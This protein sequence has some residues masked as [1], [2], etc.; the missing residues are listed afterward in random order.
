[1][2]GTSVSMEN[3]EMLLNPSITVCMPMG[4]KPPT[5]TRTPVLKDLVK[6][7]Y[8]RSG[9]NNTR[10]QMEI[11]ERDRITQSKLSSFAT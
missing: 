4:E 8:F 7:V 9:P 2:V 1:M 11:E 10:Q 5:A 3:Y 6:E